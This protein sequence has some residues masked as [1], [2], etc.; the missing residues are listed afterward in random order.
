[1]YHK[2]N[3]TINLLQN[4]RF[5]VKYR[6]TIHIITKLSQNYN[7]NVEILSTTVMFEL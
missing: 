7:F 3:L 4:Y 1:M 2:T 5:K 6:K